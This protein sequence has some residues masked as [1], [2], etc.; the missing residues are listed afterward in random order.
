M[1]K[2]VVYKD[3]EVEAEYAL[4]KERMT[5]GRKAH[6]DIPLVD[7]TVSGEHALIITVRN[8]SF[9]EDLNSTNGVKVNHKAVKKCALQDGDEIRIAKYTMKYVWEPEAASGFGGEPELPWLSGE[10]QVQTAGPVSNTQTRLDLAKTQLVMP[11]TKVDTTIHRMP[12]DGTPVKLPA[13]GIQIMSG[14]GAGKELDLSKTITTI[15]KPGL[16]VA[17]ITRRSHG[18]FLTHVEG[19]ESPR[20]NGFPIGP[21]SRALSDHDIIELAGT[22]LEFYYK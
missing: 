15:G 10:T 22:K 7:N 6:N 13:A 3:G 20:V 21:H 18:Y 12:Q 5:I 11:D 2:L 8:E 16:Q 17:V 9:L 14:P 19:G 1:S 4:Y